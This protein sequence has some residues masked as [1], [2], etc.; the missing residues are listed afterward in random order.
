[1]DNLEKSEVELI[2][3]AP[4]QGLGPNVTFW[5]VRQKYIFHGKQ[6]LVVCRLTVVNDTVTYYVQIEGLKMVDN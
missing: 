2:W 4:S 5:C 6:T 1:M 3:L